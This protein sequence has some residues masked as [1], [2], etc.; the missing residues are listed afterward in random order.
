MSVS[1]SRT[2]VYIG[3][4]ISNDLK[5]D[6]SWLQMQ[7]QTEILPR[8]RRHY[9]RRRQLEGFDDS[10]HLF[11]PSLVEGYPAFRHFRLPSG[12]SASLHGL[13]LRGVTT[14]SVGGRRLHKLCVSRHDQK[15][16][17]LKDHDLASRSELG[18]AF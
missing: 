17:V 9:A 7:S 13:L 10:R 5:G 6:I 18:E 12:A 15:C 16:C 3:W 1:L 4:D 8:S 2:A 14:A 11:E